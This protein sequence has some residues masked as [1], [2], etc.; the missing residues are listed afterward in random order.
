MANDPTGTEWGRVLEKL[1][2]LESKVDIMQGEMVVL[3][4]SMN[5]GWGIVI[6]IAGTLGIFVTDM[7]DALKRFFGLV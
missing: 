5:R 3:K 2:S 7:V 6:G 4:N 1:D